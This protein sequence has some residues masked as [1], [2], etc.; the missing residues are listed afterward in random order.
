MKPSGD[1]KTTIR[2]SQLISI[3][4][5]TLVLLFFTLGQCNA[6]SVADASSANPSSSPSSALHSHP[7]SPH[8]QPSHSASEAS[9]EPSVGSADD[10]SSNDGTSMSKVDSALIDRLLI[11]ADYARFGFEMP[12]SESMQM[13]SDV[14]DESASTKQLARPRPSIHSFPSHPSLRHSVAADSRA[15]LERATELLSRAAKMGSVAALTVLGEMELYDEREFVDDDDAANAL[16]IEGNSTLTR[17]AGYFMRA[18]E[19]GDA[20]AQHMLAV[21]AQLGLMPPSP[22]S[23]SAAAAL[24]SPEASS[25]SSAASP[26]SSALVDSTSVGLSILHDYFSAL[27][28]N[29]LAK[30]SLGYRHLYGVG[31]PKSCESALSYYADVSSKVVEST[32]MTPTPVV[33]EKARLYDESFRAAPLEEEEEFLH[34]YQTAAIN[35]DVGAM[36]SLGQC[37]LYGVRGLEKDP[38]KAA[39]YFRAAADKG[40]PSAQSHLAQLH[41]QGLGVPQSN[42]T[43][44]ELLE[45]ASKKGHPLAQNAL[46]Y[47]YLHGGVGDSGEAD[48][49]Q[50]LKYFKLASQSGYVD[51]HFNL[52]VMYFAGL[53]VDKKY[54]TAMQ[55]F[56]MAS[57]GGHTKALYNLAEM[58]AL[59]LGTMRSCALAVK[60]HKT[61]AE[62]G[63]WSSVLAEAHRSF[64]KGQ[65][66]RSWILYARAAEE[67]FEVAQTNAA[68]IM[69]QGLGMDIVEEV[70]K[71]MARQ[72]PLDAESESDDTSSSP[73]RRP[74]FRY[75]LAHRHW[76]M[77]AQQGNVEA[78][79]MLGDYAFEGLVTPTSEPDYKRAFQMYERASEHRDAQSMFNLGYMYEHG[80]GL[81]S[82]Q[83]DLHLAK[84]SYDLALE[85]DPE[86][87]LPVKA[88]I[89]KLYAKQYWQEWMGSGSESEEDSEGEEDEERPPSS[90]PT[91]SS[92]TPPG[93]KLAP[94]PGLWSWI[95]SH[96][97]AALPGFTSWLSRMTSSAS[98]AA[99]S[100]TSASSPS[101]ASVPASA[102]ASAS[103]LSASDI[104]LA[105]EDILLAMLCAALAVIVYYR[106]QRP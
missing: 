100:T 28:D 48:Y 10:I 63:E 36:V 18:A 85:F 12:S 59:G 39:T 45:A 17:A 4:L 53:G 91:A 95:R 24:P 103:T 30:L 42:E 79:R 80:L 43:A 21:M 34:Y 93:G 68:W 7:H 101:P 98:S 32:L 83:P 99:S 11:E 41:I 89:V 35:G 82:N 60:L 67:G 90:K 1:N 40:D 94:L 22:S 86:A 26:S 3:S 64:L 56:V 19:G 20:E 78:L 29:P 38:V 33:I 70:G 92:S 58:H 15:D 69:D 66:T 97:D 57:Q 55:Y 71:Q 8:G 49:K 73:T 27:G 75:L 23:T 96:L 37:H 16:G 14:D 5:S 52:G 77:A 74:P 87:I 102:S 2:R 31:V 46:G 62:R 6:Q 81:D 88:A 84:R 25:S 9:A 44:Y 106:S 54:S 76:R 50:A 104:L 51:A 47:L 72:N 13:S 61:V 65:Y 105:V